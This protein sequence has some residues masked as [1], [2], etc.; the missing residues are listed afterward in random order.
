MVKCPHY[1]TCK[2]PKLKALPS[3]MTSNTPEIRSALLS[4]LRAL[5]VPPSP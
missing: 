4:R 2:N 5:C 3:M 1:R